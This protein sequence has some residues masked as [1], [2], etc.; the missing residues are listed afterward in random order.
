MNAGVKGARA[1][2]VF[3]VM[4]RLFWLAAAVVAVVPAVSAHHSFSAEY[5]EDRT[6][7][8]EGEVEEFR[9]RNPHAWVML[10][11]QQ[12]DGSM[13]TYGA[14]WAG[15]GRLGRQGITADTIK[16]GDRVRIDGSPG[17]VEAERRIHLKGIERPADGWS[18][19][20]RNRRRR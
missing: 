7:S 2:D 11:V 10:R 13:A 15:A 8:I 16:P 12:V 3:S 6:V 1:A 19:A 14:E 17:R 18:W 4:K 20:Q 9:Y 5:F